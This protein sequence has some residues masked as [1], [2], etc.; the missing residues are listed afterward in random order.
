[1]PDFHKSRRQDMN[2][3]TPDELIGCYSHHLPP[4]MIFVIPPFETNYSVFNPQ[5][6]AV[7]N[8]NPEGGTKTSL[9]IFGT[10]P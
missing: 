5:N 6:P 8:S 4:A 1:V 7:G 10:T 3:E 2:Q 9:G